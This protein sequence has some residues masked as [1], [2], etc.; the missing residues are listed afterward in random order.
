[1]TKRNARHLQMPTPHIVKVYLAVKESKGWLSC[2]QIAKSTEVGVDTVRRQVRLLS[3]QGIF[4]KAEFFPSYLYRLSDNA[5][6]V[7]YT[8]ELEKARE[9]LNIGMPFNP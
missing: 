7:E 5:N 2:D 9:M 8:A 6:R 4:E 3:K 1:M